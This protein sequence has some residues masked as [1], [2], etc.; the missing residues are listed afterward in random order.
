MKRMIPVLFSLL[1][2]GILFPA[3]RAEE[4][5]IERGETALQIAIDHNLTME[6]L[7]LLNP[8]VDLEMMRVGD[9][10]ILPDPGAESFEAYLNARY[11][12]LLQVDDI[13]CESAADLSA[14][15]FFLAKNISALPLYGVRFTGN[16]RFADGSSA[17]AEGGT[18][19][20]QILPGERF[21]V[22]LR[23][24]GGQPEI[25]DASVSISRLDHSEAM[26]ASLRVPDTL[27][28][29]ETDILPGGLAAK[30]TIRFSA[31]AA[32]SYKDK[33]I[34]VLVSA[35]DGE[36]HPVGIRSLYTDW[37]SRL[38][39]TVYAQKGPIAAAEVRMEAY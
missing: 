5:S 32:R 19:L 25:A 1:L 38:D 39:V 11:S 8:G 26:T 22:F 17:Q 13:H 34:N 16:V 21:P 2:S 3:V 20:M 4:H 10:L 31:E 30:V 9:I 6:Q 37:Y 36:G 23:I 27:Y 7:S 24:P 14:A 18:G 15:C 33:Q 12:E 29:T 35:Y 28:K